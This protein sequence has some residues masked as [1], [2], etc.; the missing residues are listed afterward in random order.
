[1]LE[2]LE[3][4]MFVAVG[5]AIGATARYASILLLRGRLPAWFVIVLVN[6]IGCGL[7]GAAAAMVSEDYRLLVLVGILGGLTTFSTSMIDVWVL[8]H[9]KRRM[10]AAFV[11]L[12]TPLLGLGAVL[13][14][15]AAGGVL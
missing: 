10:Q 2:L 9:T 3:S 14:G 5:G 4:M 13:M 1:M 8:W 15:F 6:V 11:L 12:G 7:V